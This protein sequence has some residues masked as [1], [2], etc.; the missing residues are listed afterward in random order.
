MLY[1]PPF[2]SYL[3]SLSLSQSLSLFPAG[4]AVLLSLTMSFCLFDL[5]SASCVCLLRFCDRKFM[6]TRCHS[7]TL[8]LSFFSSSLWPLANQILTSLKYVYLI[9]FLS[10]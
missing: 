9:S 3:L 2:R 4:T 6:L 1:K 5:A 10:F 7:S 8:P